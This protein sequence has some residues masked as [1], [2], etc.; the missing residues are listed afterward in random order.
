MTTLARPLKLIAA[1]SWPVLIKIKGILFGIMVMGLGILLGYLFTSPESAELAVSVLVIIVVMLVITNKPLNG[2]LVWLAF[3]AFIET[4]VNIPMGVGLP[5]LSFSRFTLAFLAIFMLAQ[6]AVGKFRFARMGLVE[7]CIVATTLGIMICAPLS[8]QPE[9]VLQSAIT[10]HF[11]PLVLY[12]FTKNLVQTKSDFDRLFWVIAILGFVFAAYILYE[13][14]TGNILFLKK[15]VLLSYAQ[16]ATTWYGHGLRIV[17]GLLGSGA[18][19]GRALI[20]TIPIS[21]HLVFESKS[22]I[23]KALLL[24][25]VAV[26][27][28]GMF[29][30]YN[31]T[32][33]YSLLV[34]LTIMQ[35]FYSKFRKTYLVIVVV[36]AVVL[37]A[38]WDQVSESTVVE[39]R[40]NSKYSTLDSRE[41]HWQAGYNMW[42]A[43]PIRGWGFGRYETESGRFRTD[44]K[45]TNLPA[46]E[47]DYLH[48]LVA[49]GLLGL[50]PYL[51]F[52]LIPL[53][54]SVRL[55]F[56]ARA[57]GWSGFVRPE[58]I[59]V[60]WAVI[61]AFAIASYTRI[62]T[63]PLIKMLPFAVT[64]AVV[65][66][67]ECWLR[68]S[69]V[70]R[71]SA[72]HPRTTVVVAEREISSRG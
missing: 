17:R 37:W 53:L 38:T 10:M 21:F 57:P 60:Y 7:V 51:L 30:T 15:G 49:S 50:L 22:G 56:R 70:R 18:N 40:V 48:I 36:A 4:W 14:T 71:H 72:A 55:F 69:R 32:S 54:N 11:T 62:H 65:G 39:E 27:F 52:S 46:I 26:Q 6:A 33:W 41:A 67:Q 5:D 44:G 20:C 31:R 59:A 34:G 8:T 2:V 23:R 19:F 68:V 58:I 16:Y 63:E 66:T 61:I 42:R 25:M 43:K 35:F 47:N 24:G 64:G 3:T 29:L 13:Q 28:Y 9:D 1:R 12:F 45:R